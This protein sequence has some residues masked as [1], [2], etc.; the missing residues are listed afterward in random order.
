MTPL[1]AAL[2]F[3][4]RFPLPAHQASEVQLGRS[5]LCYPL[6]GLL[7]GMVLWLL[8]LGLMKLFGAGALS[9]AV[10]LSAWVL[11][12]GMMH[13]DGLADTA[14][15]WIGGL[16]D[17]ERTL[18]IM[19]D[20]ACGP[21]GVGSICLL[22]L[23]KFGALWHVLAAGDGA[24]LLLA[25]VLAPV[26][27]RAALVLLFL[28]TPY[29]RPGGIASLLV[30]N[31]P[32]RAAAAVL[33]LTALSALGLAVLVQQPLAGPLILAVAVAVFLPGRRWMSGRIGGTTGDTAG[34]ML[35]LIELGVLLA[36]CLLVSLPR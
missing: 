6:V 12:T 9:V 22:L 29:V 10:V 7:L 13:V 16:G 21:A 28:T 18:R 5:M 11:L 15:A 4:T 31:L 36:V 17:R 27:G 32:R 25:L 30:G 33:M 23:L 34:A 24:A 14:D 2:R 19:K 35:E 3:L 8:A 20:P 1:W 26:L